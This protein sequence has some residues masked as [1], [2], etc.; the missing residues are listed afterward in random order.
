[1]V[2]SS[3]TQRTSSRRASR[4]VTVIELGLIV[5]ALAVVVGGGMLLLGSTKDADQRAE[6]TQAA[7]QILL[8]AEDFR[9]ENKTG[10]PTV[11]QLKSEGLLGKDAPLHDAWGERFRV[12]CDEAGVTVIS[13]GSD[14]RIGS[15]DD[16][17]LS[18]S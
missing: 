13:S 5:S 11:T 10:C 15:E 4:G 12:Q 16:V 8:A 2:S 9:L 7:E 14:G 17:L 6:S 18:S 3:V 1:M